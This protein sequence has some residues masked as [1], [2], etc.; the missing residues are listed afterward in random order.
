MAQIV[1]VTFKSVRM[2]RSLPW[3]SPATLGSVPSSDW[4]PV[5]GTRVG[6]PV[7]RSSFR[8]RRYRYEYHSP[9]RDWVTPDDLAADH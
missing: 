7:Y 1:A 2:P 3:K 8:T 9:I 4:L 6:F 5:K